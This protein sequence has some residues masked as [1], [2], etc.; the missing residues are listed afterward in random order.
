[1]YM[2]GNVC[3]IH[4]A[5]DDFELPLQQL[6]N[7]TV[8]NTRILKSTAVLVPS[9]KKRPSE[10]SKEDSVKQRRLIVDE[11]IFETHNVQAGTSN[12]LDQEIPTDPINLDQIVVLVM[13]SIRRIR[14]T[15]NFDRNLKFGKKCEQLIERNNELEKEIVE[16]KAKI[17]DLSTLERIFSPGQ[18]RLLLHPSKKKIRWSSKDIASAISLK[19]VSPKAYRYLQNNKFPLPGLS[20]LREWARKLNSSSRGVER[21]D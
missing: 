17:P 13:A 18:I 20:T 3:S 11:A 1:M 7:Y 12:S 19:S 21:V 10:L 4:F 5:A 9:T 8:E 14:R 6:C 2:S 15:Q 16:I